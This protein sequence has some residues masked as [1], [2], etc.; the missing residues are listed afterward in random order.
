VH[1][2]GGGLDRGENGSGQAA[3]DGDAGNAQSASTLTPTTPVSAASLTVP[4]TS[5][6]LKAMLALVDRGH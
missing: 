1:L 3:A 4:A 2:A 6:W 5:P